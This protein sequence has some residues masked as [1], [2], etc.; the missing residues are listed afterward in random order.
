MIQSQKRWKI[1]RPDEKLVASFEKELSIPRIG[2]KVMAA[3][4]FQTVEEAQKFL[5]ITKDDIHNPFLLNGMEQLVE[6]VH[7]AIENEERI[8]VY[9]DYDADGITSTTVMMKVL[10]S[11]GADVIFKIPNRFIDGYGPSKRLF[12]EAFDEGVKLIITVDNGISGLE[13]IQ[14]AKELSMDVI[15][16]DHHEPG[17]MLPV[18]DVIIHPNLKDSTYPFPHLAGVGVAFKVAEALVGEELE[19]LYYL[20]AIGTIADLVSLTDENRY[21]VQQGLQQMRRTNL[22]AI[23]ALA[24]VSGVDISTINEETVGFMFGPRINAIG[25]LGDAMPGVELFLTED[26]TNAFS[27]ANKLNEKNKERQAIVKKITEQAVQLIEEA[28]T[29][30]GPSVLVIGHKD[31]NPGV[32][33]I[34]ASK[35]VEKYYRPAIVLGFD[36]EKQIAKGSARSIEGFHMYKEIAKNS[37]IVQHFGGHPMAAGLTIPLANVDEFRN[38]LVEQSK[39]C[40]TEEQLVPIIS[41]DVPLEMHEITTEAI[42]SLQ[43]LS[44]FGMDF[45]KPMYC[46]E[47]V[48]VASVRKIG[49]TQNHLKMELKHGEIGLDAI[50]FGKGELADEISPAT[51]LS[52]VGDLQINEWNG[53]KKPQLMI[54]DAKTNEWQLFDIRGIRQVNR[55]FPKIAVEKNIFVAFNEATVS[56]F[57]SLIQAEVWLFSDLMEQQVKSEY[58]TILDLPADE[59]TLI[60][61]LAYH[62]WTR[63]YAHFYATDSTYFEGL[64][65]RDQFKWY[66][67]FLAKRKSFAL[68]QH[69]HELSKHTGWSQST[70]NFMSKVFFELN[71]VRID[72][73]MLVLNDHLA[74]TD[75]SEAPAYKQREKQIELEQKLLYAPYMELKQ[76]FEERKA[77]QTVPKEEQVWI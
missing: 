60:E 64:P 30:E 38:R 77:A 61:L 21:F 20:V 4:G 34:V 63:I 45:A 70:I 19:E 42:E 10:L 40:L 41:I 25:R 75:L 51:K 74:K 48:E 67:S 71:F 5:H 1:C 15:V 6:R 59:S 49:S 56:H 24:N 43:K 53:R 39:E 35:L 13:Q 17:E 65:S 8:M 68:K 33:G 44:P 57:A 11:L 3:R 2:A 54:E 62:H 55:W 23:E 73:G 46:I 9:G 28:G 12:Q 76:W 66:F 36:E 27:I 16:T 47:G 58:V 7:Q 22:L 26:T 69:I 52:F 31:W 50:G 18:A 72:N 37:D 29:V 32:L 14:F